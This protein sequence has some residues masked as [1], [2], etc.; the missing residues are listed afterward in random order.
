MP[1]EPII[2]TSFSSKI[3]VPLVSLQRYLLDNLDKHSDQLVIDS[4]SNIS[5]T[6]H[7]ID[8]DARRMATAL[9]AIGLR[10][11][12]LFA[13]IGENSYQYLILYLGALIAGAMVFGIPSTDSY[14]SICDKII[15]QNIKLLAISATS[16]LSY[17]KRISDGIPITQKIILFNN[18][19]GLM[20]TI[21]GNNDKQQKFIT[22]GKLIDPYDTIGDDQIAV[23]PDV[24]QTECLVLSTGSSSTT[25]TTKSLVFTHY[26]VVSALEITSYPQFFG[27]TQREVIAGYCDLSQQLAIFQVFTAI[28]CGSRLVLMPRYDRPGF[29][30][31]VG[32]YRISAAIL[33][34]AAI[35]SLVKS[36]VNTSNEDNSTNNTNNSS[37]TTTTTGATDAKHEDKE[38]I[39]SLIKIISTGSC[40]HKTIA[41]QLVLRYKHI[42]DLR[43]GL[44]TT[45]CMAPVALMIKGTRDYDSSG[46]PLPHTRV[47]IRSVDSGQPLAANLVGEIWVQRPDAMAKRY[48]S[49]KPGLRDLDGWLGTGD[50]GYYDDDLL[51]YVIGKH[52]EMIRSPNN[53]LI[54]PSELE[55]SVLLHCAVD[56]AAVVAVDDDDHQSDHPTDGQQQR[57]VGFVTIRHEFVGKVAEQGI[58]DFVNNQLPKRKQLANIYIM[59]CLPKCISGK[60]SKS[61]LIKD[62]H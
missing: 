28:V 19:N 41:N 36:P 18:I 29:V 62:L 42:K 53:T 16:N 13:I 44:F 26:S 10:E 22:Y 43:Q 12:Q 31:A 46:V 39:T 49:D 51:L 6:F 21:I 52:R 24:K 57:G 25:S 3:F 59:K 55:R 56:E 37:P 9:L 61:L 20:D 54:A 58:L 50:L 15:Q 35:V 11:G 5:H 47:V 7:D 2:L 1:T 48:L 32:K 8:C 4:Q 14:Q 34:A 38:D 40:L 27:Y 17:A 60:I 23:P 30:A 33:S 45:Q